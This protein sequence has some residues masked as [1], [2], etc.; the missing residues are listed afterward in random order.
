MSVQKFEPSENTG[1]PDEIYE[2]FIIDTDVH[3]DLQILEELYPYMDDQIV[4]KLDRPMGH[5]QFSSIDWLPTWGNEGGGPGVDSNGAAKTGEDI[6]QMMK[7]MGVD[8]PLVTPGVNSL[9]QVN[10]PRMKEEVCRAYNDYLLDNVTSVHENIRGHA[11]IPLWN[12][13]ATVEELERI[14]DEEDV[15]GAYAW[16]G[17]FWRLGNPEYDQV[18]EKL[19][20][21]D[22]PLTL[23]LDVAS[24]PDPST[25]NGGA[26]RTWIEAIGF[27][28]CMHS[29]M[30]T[31]NMIVTGVFDKYPNLNIV[32]QEGGYHWLPFLAYR[33]DEFYQHTPEDIQLAERMYDSGQ[34]YLDRL[35][36]EYL[37]DNFYFSTQPVCLPDS[38]KHYEW[39]LDIEQAEKT[40]IFA[41]DWPHSTNDPPT[42]VIENSAI[43]EDLRESLFRGNAREVYRL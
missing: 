17:K 6:L 29:M 22:L 14:G 25:P 38:T 28:P 1:I 11:M 32:Y 18:Y 43:D 12:P 23:H 19:T 37:F 31:V 39:L 34:K 10:Y 42:W 33:M 27:A 16:F 35:P 30:N 24:Y 20:D 40:M 7:N 15:A 41:T 26:L 8:I 4:N 9:P 21:L 36:S 3:L 2:E 13:E 5:Y